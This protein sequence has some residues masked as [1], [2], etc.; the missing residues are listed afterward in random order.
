VAALWLSGSVAKGDVTGMDHLPTT[1]YASSGDA[2]IAYQVLGHGPLDVLMVPGFPSHLELAWEYP[3]LASFYRHLASVCRLILMD[4]RG[5]GLSDR[6][7]P[8]QLPG[9]EQRAVD[10]G[11]VLDDV[12]SNRVALVGASDGG[13]IAALFAAT[14]PERTDRLVLIN[15]YARRIRSDDYPWGPTDEEWSA[16]ES[17]AR[18]HWGEPLFLDLLAPGHANDAGFIEWWARLLRQS[19][20]PGSAVAYLA[21]NRGV[22]VR[23]V[24]AAIH[25][26]TLVIHRTNDRINPVAGARLMAEL[27]PGARFV[28]L[29]GDEHH[30]WLGDPGTLLGEV[31]EFLTGTRGG[32]ASDRVLATL[33]FTDI[34][35]STQTAARLGDREWNVLLET[36]RDIVRSELQ[37]HR[38]REMGTTGDGFLALFDG[39]ERAVRCALALI[40]RL[41][42]I[43]VSIRAGVHTS[44]VEVTGGNVAGLGV[45]VAARIMSLAEPGEVLVSTVV[46]DLALGSGLVFTDRGRHTLR[47]VPGEWELLAAS[48]GDDRS[49]VAGV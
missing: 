33:L 19:V 39:P 14:H 16:F 1:R 30:P 40:D 8:S 29:P 44:E 12:G 45:H 18:D 21:M 13:P 25:V 46:R 32:P 17:E 35:R 37:R 15:T 20:S 10:L 23:Q 28:E 47:G 7:P 27:I 41:G 38:G 49:R 48:T 11:A 6:I 4:K 9:V 22:D 31:E 43:G 26:P 2:G 5:I 36:H 42:A 24:L 34:V 3:P